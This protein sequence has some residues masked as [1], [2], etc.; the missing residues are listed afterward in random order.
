M[1]LVFDIFQG[2]GIAAAIGVRPF[3]PAFVVTLLAAAG[4]ETHLESTRFEFVHSSYS[5]LQSLPFL[6]VMAILAV[7]LIVAESGWHKQLSSRIGVAALSAISVVLGALLS[8]GDLARG[9]HPVWLGYVVGAIFA[10]V[11][12]YASRPFLSRL[13][14]R[15]DAEAAAI[16]V[17]L[18]GEGSA[19]LGAVAS[20]L[21]PPLGIV[22]VL[23][24]IVLGLRGR[25]R[26]GQKYAGLRILR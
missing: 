21:V 8:A 17:P 25:G 13:R 15:L 6:L 5:F 3:L 1:E 24:L 26:E 20:V 22:F 19:L 2:I 10:A 4:L 16:G 14:S 9:H 7:A 12:I 11:G 23:A 18:V